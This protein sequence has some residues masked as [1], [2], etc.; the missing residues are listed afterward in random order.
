M[1]E[2]FRLDGHVY[3]ASPQHFFRDA[4]EITQAEFYNALFMRLK[5]LKILS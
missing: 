3:Y 2:K 1:S 5:R 4:T